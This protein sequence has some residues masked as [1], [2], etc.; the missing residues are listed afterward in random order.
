MGRHEGTHAPHSQLAATIADFR[1]QLR[2]LGLD[3]DRFLSEPTTASSKCLRPAVSAEE[4]LKL[5]LRAAMAVEQRKNG[6]ARS[7]SAR[8]PARPRRVGRPPFQTT[9]RCGN[10]D[11]MLGVQHRTGTRKGSPWRYAHFDEAALRRVMERYA[12]ILPEYLRVRNM[13]GRT[14]LHFA[15]RLDRADLVRCVCTSGGG[16]KE[17]VNAKCLVE[18]ETA[19]HVAAKNNAAAT[20][21]TLLLF[22]AD[23]SVTDAGGATPFDRALEAESA[24]RA[25]RG[26]GK[27]R[28]LYVS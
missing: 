28:S 13:G 21:R 25:A 23:L 5:S 1:S 6:C 9:A 11:L 10:T 14:V 27:T 12:P 7:R 4:K 26:L 16:S 24:A 19:L 8:P 15:A 2:G 22:S 3:A 18:G 20:V 17:V